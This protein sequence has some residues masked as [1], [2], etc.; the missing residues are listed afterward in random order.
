MTVSGF[1]DASLNGVYLQNGVFDGQPYYE[2]TNNT[3][4]VEYRIEYGPYTFSGAYY[5]VAITQTEGSIDIHTPKYRILSTDP[6][7]SGWESMVSPLSGEDTVGTVSY[8]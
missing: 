8:V 3:G 2:K 1:G 5:I 6:T 4:A 7:G